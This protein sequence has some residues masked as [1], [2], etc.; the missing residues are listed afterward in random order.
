MISIPAFIVIAP[1]YVA[2][3]LASHVQIINDTAATVT[4]FF[5]R[6]LVIYV[7]IL[8]HVLWPPLFFPLGLRTGVREVKEGGNYGI[9]SALV[10]A[11][12]AGLGMFV[13][14]MLGCA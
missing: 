14:S 9:R 12:R 7:F 10:N 13:C 5:G 3:L 1:I 11:C 2:I 8:I 4:A 6:D